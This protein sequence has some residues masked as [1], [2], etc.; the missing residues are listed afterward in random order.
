MTCPHDRQQILTYECQPYRWIMQCKHCNA[1]FAMTRDN[2][3]I[4]LT[5][6]ND[7]RDPPDNELSV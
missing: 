7:Y 2:Y 4:P 5:P 6:E 1:L 3:R